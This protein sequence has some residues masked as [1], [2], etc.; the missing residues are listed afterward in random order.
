MIIR[1]VKLEIQAKHIHNFKELTKHEK[2][3]ILAFKGCSYLEVMQDISNPSIFFTQSHWESESALNKYRK[4]DFFRRN[5]EQVKQW[6]KNKPE[7]W[8]L[9]KTN[10]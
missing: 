3:D 1:F 10:N 6:F 7:A 2:P 8:S 4:S 5:W 9:S